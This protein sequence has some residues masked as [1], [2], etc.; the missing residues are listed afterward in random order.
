MSKVIKFYVREVYGT[1][2]CYI[3]PDNKEDA[4]IIQRLTGKKTIDSTTRELIRDLSG[5]AINFE[6]TF[7]P[8]NS[9]RFS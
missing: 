7:I 2:L 6:Q 9:A 1:P 5:G 3:H 8:V 4:E